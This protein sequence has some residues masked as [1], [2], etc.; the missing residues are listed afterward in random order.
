[1]CNMHYDVIGKVETSKEDMNY[2]I[3]KVRHVLHENK[4]SKQLKSGCSESENFKGKVSF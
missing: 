1:M 4:G 3:G 2:I